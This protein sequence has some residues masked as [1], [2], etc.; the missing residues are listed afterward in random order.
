MRRCWLLGVIAIV[1]LGS[2]LAASSIAD[3]GTPPTKFPAG[4]LWSVKSQGGLCPIREAFGRSG[5]FSWIA[6]GSR[7]FPGTYKSDGRTIT[8]K[9][10]GHQ[11]GPVAFI[12]TWSKTQDEYVGTLTNGIDHDPATLS[13]GIV[14]GCTA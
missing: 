3:A 11:P 2:A 5:H 8:E 14:K 1:T 4:A 7:P 10:P 6:V 9:A 12:G 13:R